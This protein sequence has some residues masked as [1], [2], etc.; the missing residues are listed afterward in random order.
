MIVPRTPS[1]EASIV[2]EDLSL[3][4]LQRLARERLAQVKVSYVVRSSKTVHEY[5]SS[6]GG[7]EFCQEGLAGGQAG[8]R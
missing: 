4:E 2:V 7:D 3:E 6:P 1:P 5:S 8:V